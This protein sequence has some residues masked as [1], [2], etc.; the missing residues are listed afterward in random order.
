[1]KTYLET[2]RLI[3]REFS[4]ADV[5][6]LVDLDSD[7]EVTRYINGGKS[8]PR[9]YIVEQIMP[10]IFKYYHDLD[11]QGIWAAIEKTSGTFLGWFHLRPNHA[12]PSETELGY[13]LKQSSW[14][15]GLATEGSMALVKKG[16]EELGVDV[17][18]A[19]ADPA[20]TASRRVME[21]VGLQF[22]EEII[23]PDGFISVKY[24]LDRINYFKSAEN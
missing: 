9:V 13:R 11:R 22:E 2:N 20:N 6:N 21:K 3:L 7:P 23:E 8:T 16:F 17:I 10:R 15:Q 1:M 4:D 14:G 24:K 19:L 5:D 18:V 12:E